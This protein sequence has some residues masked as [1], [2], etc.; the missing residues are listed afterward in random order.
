MTPLTRRVKVRTEP[1]PKCLRRQ[2]KRRRGRGAARA[3]F[4]LAGGAA[5][6]RLELAEVVPADVGDQGD[7]EAAARPADDVEATAGGL[8]AR[9]RRGVGVDQH[10]DGVEPALVDERGRLVAL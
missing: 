2:V 7:A 3:S 10:R 6:A 8:V 5:E 9:P 4:L 1:G